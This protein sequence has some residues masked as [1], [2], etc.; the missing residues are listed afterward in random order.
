[1]WR[2]IQGGRSNSTPAPPSAP[3]DTRTSIHALAPWKRRTTTSVRC[4]SPASSTACQLRA[5][6]CPSSRLVQRHHRQIIFPVLATWFQ[7]KEVDRCGPRSCQPCQRTRPSNFAPNQP[8]EPA[9]PAW[10]LPTDDRFRPSKAW[11]DFGSV[12]DKSRR[13]MSGYGR[14]KSKGKNERKATNRK[15]EKEKDRR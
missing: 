12:Q 5:L 10:Q 14:Q 2:R 3:R 15:K 8:A 6:S 4:P 7:V 13:E 1:M 9:V 11:A